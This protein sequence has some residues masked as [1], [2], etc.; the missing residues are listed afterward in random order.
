MTFYFH[1]NPTTRVSDCDGVT[2]QIKSVKDFNNDEST[3]LP[4]FIIFDPA[5]KSLTVSTD[6][7]TLAETGQKYYAV[8]ISG[9]YNEGLQS[10][11]DIKMVIN[12]KHPCFEGMSIVKT[13]NNTVADS[14]ELAYDVD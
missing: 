1:N 2:F 13:Y 3:S 14:T 9:T 6:D 8:T 5:Q 10:Y 7:L 4:P 11:D 12:F